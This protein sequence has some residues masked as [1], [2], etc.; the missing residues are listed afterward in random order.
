MTSVS[1]IT[2]RRLIL[3]VALAFG[4]GIIAADYW[5]IP[6]NYLEC[7]VL[8]SFVVLSLVSLRRWFRPRLAAALCLILFALLGALRYLS[9]TRLLPA[10]HISRAGLYDKK[11]FL[12]GRVVAEPERGP[13]AFVLSW[14]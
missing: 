1:D 10:N 3:W 5:P 2:R 4:S 12:K 9:V 7:S 14:H 8:G 6:L 13:G 11:G